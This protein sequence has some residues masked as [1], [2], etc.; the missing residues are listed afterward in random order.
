MKVYK[1]EEL[2][3]VAGNKYRGVVVAAKYA[4]ELNSLPLQRSPYADPKLTTLA[5]ETLTSGDLDFRISERRPAS[6]DE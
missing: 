5:L 2:E 4:R 1:P 6:S 3:D